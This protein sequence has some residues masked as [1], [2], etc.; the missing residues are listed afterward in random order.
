V[1]STV[2]IIIGKKFTKFSLFKYWIVYESRRK[3]RVTELAEITS[4]LSSIRLM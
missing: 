2:A 3:F 4:S 1:I